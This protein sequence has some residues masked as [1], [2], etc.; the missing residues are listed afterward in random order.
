MTNSTY[1]AR[2]ATRLA[3]LTLCLITVG[4]MLSGCGWRL[5]GMQSLNTNITELNV[6]YS[7]RYS[8]L[9]N[10]FDK[11][12]AQQGITITEDNS[13]PYTLYLQ[14]ENFERRS[15]SVGSN[16]LSAQYELQMQVDFRLTGKDF[17]S[18]PLNANVT[19]IYDYDPDDTVGKR[20]EEQIILKEMRQEIVNRILRQITS[21]TN[22]AA[23]SQ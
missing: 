14:P 19:R 11:T 21:L 12:L 18:K 9:A 22:Q 10:T 8:L 7:D 20:A 4:S 5:R 13:A 17:E 16:G 1:R 15:A 2:L 23:E 3:A 6:K